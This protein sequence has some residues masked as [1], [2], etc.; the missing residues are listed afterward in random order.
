MGTRV[1]LAPRALADLERLTDFLLR[2]DAPVTA[3]ET[4]PILRSGLAVL[5]TH[6]L[7]GR[8]VEHDLRELVMSRGRTGYV[9]LY[10]YDASR[11]VVIVLAVRHQREGGYGA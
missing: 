2:A 8:K 10:D 3:A 9:A 6:P 1:V 4:L 7:I 11:D 5:G